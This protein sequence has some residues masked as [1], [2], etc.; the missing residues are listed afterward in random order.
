MEGRGRY[1]Y[2]HAKSKNET[3]KVVLVAQLR[4]PQPPK[5]TAY[6]P[7]L[8]VQRTRC[9]LAAP[10]PGGKVCVLAPV[11]RRQRNSTRTN[12]LGEKLAHDG[13][14]KR[15]EKEGRDN[16]HKNGIFPSSLVL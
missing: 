1:G 5:V 2:V 10:S 13:V 6:A 12:G 14:G 8:R 4:S 9:A 3:E 16:G 15:V 11:G 7:V